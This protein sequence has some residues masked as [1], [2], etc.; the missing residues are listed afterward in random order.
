VTLLLALASVV[1]TGY[2]APLATHA[3]ALA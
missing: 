2:A 1:L 3:L